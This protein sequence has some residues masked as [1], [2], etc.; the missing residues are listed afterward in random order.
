MVTRILLIEDEPY[1]LEGHITALQE[2]GYE[3]EVAETAVE[4]LERLKRPPAPALLI[5]D[6]IMPYSRDEIGPDNG[7]TTGLYLLEVIRRDLKLAIPVIMLTIVA[8]RDRHAQ[9]E[10]TERKYG[11]MAV[12]RVKPYLPS[13]LLEDVRSLLESESTSGG[14]EP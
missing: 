4:A 9:I 12:I 7:T 8:S 10:D 11:M 13:E 3:V 5:I 1:Y 6:L 2:A 14:G